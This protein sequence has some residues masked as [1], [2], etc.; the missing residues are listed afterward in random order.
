MK[1]TLNTLAAL[2]VVVLLGGC[3]ESTVPL[4]SSMDAEIDP[5]LTGEWELLDSGDKPDRL[6]ILPFN[7][8]EYYIEWVDFDEDSDEEERMR[9]RAFATP[10]GNRMF[11]NVQNIDLKSDH[12]YIF[13]RYTL[14]PDGQLVLQGLDQ[15][16]LK[17][18]FDSSEDFL[19]YMKAH[20]AEEQ[21]YDEPGYFRKVTS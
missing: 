15:S 12:T 19:D 5:A 18:K 10:V 21:L 20:A 14:E 8:H 6:L 11:A 1:Q 4:S 13:F 2:V 16:N 7:E 9:F 3:Y 17:M